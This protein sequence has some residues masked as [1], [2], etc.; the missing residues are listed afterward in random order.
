MQPVAVSPPPIDAYIEGVRAGDRA[1]LA[2]AITLVESTK[3]AHSAMAQKLLQALL[4]HT[5]GAMR[6]G[7]TGVPGVGKSTTIDMFGMNIVNAG[8]SVAVLAVDPTSKRTGGSILG[9]KT[10][11]SQLAQEPRAFIRP[12]PSSCTL[13]GVTRKTRET[14]ALCEAAG[15]D[16]IIVETV[17]VGQSEIAVADMVDFFLVLLLAGGGDDLQG[18]K[19]GIIEIADMIAINKADGDNVLRAERAAADYRG[20]MQILTPSSPA[21]TPPVITISGRENKGLDKLWEQILAHRKAL[22][23]TGEL[24]QRRQRQAVAWMHD[25]LSD[26]IMEMVHANPRVAARMAGIEDDVRQGRLLPTL[27]V[28]EI[29][30][31]IGAGA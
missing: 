30:S 18:I 21:W 19:K 10:R 22:G 29:M 28:D 23:E 3:P 1:M 17:G 2:R 5:G 4:P 8:L 27:A 7:V 12:S 16:V 13:G 31:L 6:L 14:M 9:D 26:R 15:F 20:A 24:A 11:M 25:M